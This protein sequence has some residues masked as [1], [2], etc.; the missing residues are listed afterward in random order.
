MNQPPRQQP[1]IRLGTGMITAA[2]IV[3]LGMMTV[4]FSGWLEEQDNPNRSVEGDTLENGVR[5]IVLR[6]NRSGH[7]VATGSIDNQPVV[8]LL[9]TG[10]TTVSVP[11]QLAKRLRLS[12]GAARPTTTANGTITTYATTLSKVQLGTLTL[13]GIRANINPHMQGDEVLLGMSFLKRVEFTQKSNQLTLRQYP[14]IN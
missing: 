12:R 2:W 8:F 1:T 14:E 3:L 5:E 11:G 10:A 6:P 9:D 7:Y 13:H 4:F